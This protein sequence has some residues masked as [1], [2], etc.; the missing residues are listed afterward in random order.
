MHGLRIY[1]RAVPTTWASP[2]CPFLTCLRYESVNM[3]YWQG[4][5][6]TC[7]WT[8]LFAHGML[9]G[10]REPYGE[11]CPL[12]NPCS[13]FS[14]SFILKRHSTLVSVVL[15]VSLAPNMFVMAVGWI[16]LQPFVLLFK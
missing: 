4:P 9:L 13:M 5:L 11:M 16:T 3:L 1:L 7:Q 14:R 2:K 6:R 10:F 15:C 8:P 12:L